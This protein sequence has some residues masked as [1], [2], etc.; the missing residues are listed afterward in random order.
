M[1][2]IDLVFLP[3]AVG[4]HRPR[5]AQSVFLRLQHDGLSRTAAVHDS[6]DA[7]RRLE[8]GADE[9]S[10][11]HAL[12]PGNCQFSFSF[13][14]CFYS[15]LF[16]QLDKIFSKIYKIPSM[17][18]SLSQSVHRRIEYSIERILFRKT[19]TGRRLLVC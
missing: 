16:L 18:V 13:R 11:Q 12:P 10:A 2:L 6:F 3:A 19:W 7:Q 14:L 8:S 9:A 1:P 4:R 5:F 17:R 15:S